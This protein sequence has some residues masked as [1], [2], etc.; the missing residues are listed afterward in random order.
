MKKENPFQRF[1]RCCLLIAL[2]LGFSVNVFADAIKNNPIMASG[3]WGDVLGATTFSAANNSEQTSF[4]SLDV[5]EICWN[6]SAHVLTMS[7]AYGYVT[8]TSYGTATSPKYRITNGSN[9]GYTSKL[10]ATTNYFIFHAPKP[11]K[12]IATISL[13]GYK[14]ST[15]VIVC[16]SLYELSGK[17]KTKIKVSVNNYGAGY[18]IGSGSKVD[19]T[20]LI[21]AD[22]AGLNADKLTIK[23]ARDNYNEGDNCVLAISDFYVYGEVDPLSIEVDKNP[24]EWGDAIN[25]SAETGK[26]FDLSLVQWQKSTNGGM[27]FNVDIGQGAT[28]TDVP[29]LGKNYYR[30]IYTDDTGVAYF[31]EPIVVDAILACSDEASVV[32]F[33][34]NFGQLEEETDRNEG[35]PAHI[36]VYGP[37]NPDGY[38]YVDD[39]GSLKDEGTYA[40]MANPRYGG[41]NVNGVTDGCG[42]TN[43]KEGE[44]WYR[45]IMD[46]TQGGKDENGK[47]GGMLLVN[48]KASLVYSRQVT[49]D[50]QNTMMNFS[51]WFASA[52]GPMPGIEDQYK[53]ISMQFIVKDENYNIIEEATLVVKNIDYSMGWV[54]GETSFNSGNNTVLYV[55]IYNY[56]EGGQGNDFLVDDIRFTVC[57]PKV[58]I[59]AYSRSND[60]TIDNNKKEVSGLCDEPIT[61]EVDASMAMNFF[62]EPYYVWFAK[63]QGEDEFTSNPDWNGNVAIQVS[64]TEQAQYYV[65]VMASPEMAE[66]YLAGFVNPCELVAMSPI[67][68]VT[69]RVP[70]PLYV[71]VVNRVCND[72]TL[73]ASS[74]VEVDYVWQKSIDGGQTWV[75][76]DFSGSEYTVTIT[77]NTMFRIHNDEADSYPTSELEPWSITLTVEPAEVY[78]GEMITATVSV[79][80]FRSNNQPVWSANGNQMEYEGYTYETKPYAPTEY[81]VSLEGCTSNAAAVTK[82]I[83][84]TVFT[85]LLVDGFN[86]DFIVGMDPV[87]ALKIYD[88]YGNLLVETADGWD[89]LDANGN[90]ALPGVYY[91]VATMPNGDVVKGNVEL[92]NEKK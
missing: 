54:K 29:S 90:Y 26:D 31:S 20:M 39:C 13:K 66:E 92:L 91:Y 49:I 55:E 69:C 78:L 14:P 16:F 73:R 23:L 60:V 50:C 87:V 43:A 22:Y 82:V 25:L 79:E 68:N 30:A 51:A 67:M 72:I 74:E 21:P 80:G 48:G 1:T 76:I 77:E 35:D 45:D 5:S 59:Q 18:E 2:L 86:D 40:V 17:D 62:K 3:L 32:I 88:R 38:V 44:M 63:M 12:D 84:P 41:C 56:Q 46:K 89:G 75:D 11:Q 71:D 70:T 85:P 64:V 6:R 58:D 47:Y 36:N 37:N 8:N 53:P 33:E 52:S 9:S 15:E 19:V 42:C 28:I 57:A 7:S 83:W 10:D 4:T 61:L 34:E 81:T 65:M 27:D 24:V